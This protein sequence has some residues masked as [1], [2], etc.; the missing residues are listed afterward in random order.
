MRVSA[1]PCLSSG[2]LV[3]ESPRADTLSP[4]VIYEIVSRI[5]ERDWKASSPLGCVSFRLH[6]GR[7]GIPVRLFVQRQYHAE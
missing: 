1:S 6:D 2:L 4:D 7:S 5:L 3:L